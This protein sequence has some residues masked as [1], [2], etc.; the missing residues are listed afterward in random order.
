MVECE[1][2]PKCPEIMQNISSQF[3]NELC[4]TEK[5]DLVETDRYCFLAHYI[6]DAEI[7][8]HLYCWLFKES[9]NKNKEDF[10]ED[11]LISLLD[12]HNY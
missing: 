12:Y 1:L 7:I 9:D 2:S 5:E 10:P 8:R 3:I 11:K 6:N 4:K